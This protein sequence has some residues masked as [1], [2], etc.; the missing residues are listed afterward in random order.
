MNFMV[1][2][3]EGTYHSILGRPLLTKFMAVYYSYLVLKMPKE[4]G[5]LT[6]SGNIYIAYSLEE[7][8]FRV[9]EAIDLSVQ[10]TETTIQATKTHPPQSARDSRIASSIKKPQVQRAQGDSIG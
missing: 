9:T 2:D 4:K 8:S 3:F 10:T 5:V 6:L 7:E 1:A